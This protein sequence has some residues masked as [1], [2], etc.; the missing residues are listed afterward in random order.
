MITSA[1]PEKFGDWC[2]RA[3]ECGG[4]ALDGGAMFGSAPRPLWE[5]L[6]P[7]DA[8]NRI[9]L[10][11][12]L[13]LLENTR[14]A[15]RV[16]VDTGI[17]DKYDAVFAERFAVRSPIPR[18]SAAR[19]PAADARLPLAIALNHLDLALT[20][21]THVMLTHLHFDH[22]GGV[23][24]RISTGTATGELAPTF[25]H[26]LHFLQRRNLATAE[27][28]NLRERA[29]YLPENVEPL[30]HVRLQLLDGAEEVL[31]G[32]SVLPSDGHTDGLQA[33]RLEGGGQ[34]LYYLADLAPTHHHLHPAFTMGYDLCARELMVEKQRLF[35]RALDERAVIVFEHDSQ[36]AAGRL[37]LK[38]EKFFLADS[39]R[40]S[41]SAT[42]ET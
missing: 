13:L 23:S 22:G 1:A 28:P 38:G 7:P 34:V 20:D 18:P 39:L 36:V 3:V 32:L 31:P 10:A 12:R 15:V 24:R 6:V 4:L 26:A 14:L 11:M 8:L 5:K 33:V 29:S 2:V 25:P 40:W 9:P 42:A 27:R 17:G 35:Q 41:T 21:V 16:L 37:G 19:L 30:R